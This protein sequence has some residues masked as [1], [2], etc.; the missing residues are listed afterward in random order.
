MSRLLISEKLPADVL[1]KSLKSAVDGNASAVIAN[2]SPINPDCTASKLVS[3]S[4][5]G[6]SLALTGDHAANGC[7]PF[8]DTGVVVSV[9]LNLNAETV[10]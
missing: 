5:C 9:G 8:P 3:N 2:L 6:S 1:K 4:V 7:P 10:F